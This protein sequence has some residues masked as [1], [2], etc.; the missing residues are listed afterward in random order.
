M[1]FGSRTTEMG[2]S[3]VN[4]NFAPIKV[5][6]LSYCVAQLNWEDISEEGKYYRICKL[7]LQLIYLFVIEK[8]NCYNIMSSI[9]I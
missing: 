2:R 4:N 3:V 9:L 5:R 7:I 1:C 8:I 6:V